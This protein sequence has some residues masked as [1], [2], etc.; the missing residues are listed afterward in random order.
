MFP[1]MLADLPAPAST[2]VTSQGWIAALTIEAGTDPLTQP[3]S[4]YA[5]HDTFYAK[6]VVTKN[7]EPLTQAALE[8]Y[9]AYELANGA[10]APPWFSIVNLYG[11]LDSQINTRLP[12]S[13]AYSDRDA[14]WVFQNYAS[15][16]ESESGTFIDGLTDALTSAQPT[17]NFSAYLNYLDPS[18]TPDQAADL[19]Y[20]ADLYRKLVAIKEIV[21]PTAVFWNPQSI[22]NANL[23]AI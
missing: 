8:S 1:A 9:F 10:S 13:S 3:L 18:L 14:L 7:E 20:G 16:A 4:G 12:G 17:G 19:Y 21:D 23:S 22:G 2:N 6:S 15:A 11:G 5:E